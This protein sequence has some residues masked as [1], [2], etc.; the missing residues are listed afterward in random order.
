[1]TK[2]YEKFQEGL[3]RTLSEKT[4]ECDRP[5]IWSDQDGPRPDGPFSTI[6]IL[7]FSSSED[8]EEIYNFQEGTIQNISRITST[9]SVQFYGENSFSDM[10]EFK[11]QIRVRS[12]LHEMYVAF[13]EL[14]IS[15]DFALSNNIQNL[16]QVLGTNF[17]DRANID[18]VFYL[19][20]EIIDIGYNGEGG[21]Y[22]VSELE[23]TGDFANTEGNTNKITTVTKII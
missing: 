6:K 17:E 12:F 14:G 13:K 1:M 19:V 22:E 18:L 15:V 2:I 21:S 9:V 10:H 4:S 5:L 8:D 23:I 16:S 11:K 20:D 3:W 7:T